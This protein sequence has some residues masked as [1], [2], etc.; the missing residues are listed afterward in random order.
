MASTWLILV[1]AASTDSNCCFSSVAEC[2]VTTEML[3][4]PTH[5]V[6]LPYTYIYILIKPLFSV[7][8]Q[9]VAEEEGTD[10]RDTQDE[11]TRVGLVPR[12]SFE[13]DRAYCL[14]EFPMAIN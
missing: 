4:Y 8:V 2:F 12:L 11:Q 1:I 13:A 3:P 5:I 6:T 9:L 10:A 14:V 7:L